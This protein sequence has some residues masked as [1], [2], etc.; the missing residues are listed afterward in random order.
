M[1]LPFLFL[2]SGDAPPLRYRLLP[3]ESHVNVPVLEARR[4]AGLP[5]TPAVLHAGYVSGHNKARARGSV[6]VH[7]RAGSCLDV[8]VCVVVGVRACARLFVLGARVGCG[9]LPY[10]ISNLRILQRCIQAS[11]QRSLVSV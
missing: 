4:A 9:V 2:G 1:L 7:A 11:A 8:C 10:F 3:L 6:C 5:T